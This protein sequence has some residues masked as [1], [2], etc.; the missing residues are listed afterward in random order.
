MTIT[1]KTKSGFEFVVEKDVIDDME[2]IDD[3][4]DAD[5]GNP[6]AVSRVCKRILGEKQQKR[7]YDHLRTQDGRVPIKETAE[8]LIDI[9]VE[10]GQ[11]GKN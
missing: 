8:A 3:L 11:E 2:L 1:G 4:A 5:E 6:L 9:M 10:L 7:L